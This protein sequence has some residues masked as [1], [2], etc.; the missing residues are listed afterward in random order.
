MK[1]ALRQNQEV[2]VVALG[3]SSTEGWHASDIAHSY[4]ALLQSLLNTAL[5]A[6]HVAVLNRGVGGQDVTEM[7]PRI[8]R[9]VLGVR[10]TLVIWQVGANGAMKHMPAELF[11]RLLT[12]GVQRLREAKVDVVLMD[13]QRAPAILAAP[14]NIKFDQAM[15]EVAVA[16]GA[17]L[18]DRGALMDLWRASGFPYEQFMSEDGVHHNDFG[19]R[20]VS[21]ALAQSLLDGLGPSS[22]ASRAVADRSPK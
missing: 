20:C 10:P 19:Y 5:P 21:E 11:K 12:N 2:T 6:A 7:L 9:D 18:F 15:A 8:E 13:N 14:D 22:T 17:A 3:S 4:P 16:T 1:A